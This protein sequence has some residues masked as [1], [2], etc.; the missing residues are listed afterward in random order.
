MRRMHVFLLMVLSAILL[1]CCGA[2]LGETLTLP[3]DLTAIDEQA[4]YTDG[5]LDRVALPE[6]LLTIGSKA[7][8]RSGVMAVNLPDSL[9]FI[10]DDAFDETA[11]T[12]LTVN[13]GTYA[14]SLIHI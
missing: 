8:A 6:G 10:A 2:G 3:E 7:F 11:I 13:E 9:T 4:F 5:S 1:A 14:L 12:E